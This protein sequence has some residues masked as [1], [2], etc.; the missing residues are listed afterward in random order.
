M[1]TSNRQTTINLP[2]ATIKFMTHIE[3]GSI[4][5]LTDG[6]DFGVRLKPHGV[7]GAEA[8]R[9]YCFVEPGTVDIKD[10]DINAAKREI[11]AAILTAFPMANMFGHEPEAAG[12]SRIDMSEFFWKDADGNPNAAW[13]S[14]SEETKYQIASQDLIDNDTDGL[15]ETI[16]KAINHHGCTG[17]STPAVILLPRE[18]KLATV[19][20]GNPNVEVGVYE[21]SALEEA[22]MKEESKDNLLSRLTGISKKPAEMLWN[23]FGKATGMSEGHKG[24][25]I[26][27]T[28]PNGKTAVAVFKFD[29]NEG[30][31][32]NPETLG[33]AVVDA[34]ERERVAI[35]LAFAPEGTWVAE[36]QANADP[37]KVGEVERAVDAE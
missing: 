24:L 12:A 22:K 18:N 27:L 33:K 19:K 5:T 17:C 20:F 16:L 28:F 32:Y 13:L 7:P 15:G 31:W 9:F 4:T 29:G 37:S 2:F 8:T 3:P 11:N 6:P 21:K 14:L 1:N 25:H 30:E 26:D 35:A 23:L 10:V 34:I 36:A